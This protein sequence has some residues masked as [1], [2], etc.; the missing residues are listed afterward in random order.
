MPAHRRRRGFPGLPAMLLS[1]APLLILS[2]GLCACT[3]TQVFR[4][5]DV[6]DP[7]ELPIRRT[8]S[9]YRTGSPPTQLRGFLVSADRDSLRLAKSSEEPEDVRALACREVDSITYTFRDREAARQGAKAAGIVVGGV[10][11]A[12]V[13]ATCLD[14]DKGCKIPW[15]ED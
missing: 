2:L 3:T 4:V 8:V 1:H 14:S 10:M 5:A 11:M 6:C 9:V 13:V 7:H 12:F 15:L